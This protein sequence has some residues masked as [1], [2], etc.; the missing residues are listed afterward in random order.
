MRRIEIAAVVARGPGRLCDSDA[1]SR[2]V[3][4]GQARLGPPVARDPIMPD[5]QV[6]SDRGTAWHRGAPCPPGSGS[7]GPDSDFAESERTPN[8]NPE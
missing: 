4:H 5:I 1:A 8:L 7:P 2:F 6:H 3:L